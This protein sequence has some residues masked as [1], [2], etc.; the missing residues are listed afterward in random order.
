MSGILK[1]DTLAPFLFIIVLDYVLRISLDAGYEKGLLIH[2]RGSRR[3]PSVHVTAADVLA[4]TSGT[5]QNAEELRHAVEE[6]AAHVG[7]H[8]NTTKTETTL[9]Y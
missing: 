9:L 7:L 8:C 6:A 4:I 2:P 5:V 1:G 3:H